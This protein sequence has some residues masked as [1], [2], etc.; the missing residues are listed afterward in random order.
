MRT[1]FPLVTRG[2]SPLAV[3]LL[4]TIFVA[5]AV[6]R[7]A[8]EPS[9]PLPAAGASAP[10]LTLRSAAVEDATPPRAAD[11]AL[12]EALLG[13]RAV[14]P[15]PSDADTLAPS[16]LCSWAPLEAG[17]I[18]G[19]LGP[20]DCRW[21]SITGPDAQGV[22]SA[23]PVDVYELRLDARSTLSVSFTEG[24]EIAALGLY[25]ANFGLLVPPVPGQG[26]QTTLPAGRFLLVVLGLGPRVATDYAMD[27]ALAPASAPGACEPEP[28]TAGNDATGRLEPTGCQLF[29][30][31]PGLE[32]DQPSAVYELRLDEPGEVSLSLAS[33]GAFVPMLS[34][35]SE[36]GAR[37]IATAR[38]D[39]EGAT[40]GTAALDLHLAPGAYWLLVASAQPGQGG[41][42]SLG[43]QLQPAGAVCEPTDLPLGET[44]NAGLFQDSCR[45]SYLSTAIDDPAPADVYRLV[46]PQTGLL[47]IEFEGSG[48]TAAA[49]VFGDRFET[50]LQDPDLLL[51]SP[52][53]LDVARPGTYLVAIQGAAGE[54]GD[55]SVTARLVPDAGTCALQTLPSLPQTI[56]GAL[57]VDD[58]SL[59]D[60]A[61]FNDDTKVDLYY[62]TLPER[63]RLSA[64]LVAPDF[65]SY[66]WVFS[67]RADF[68]IGAGAEAGE[69]A[70]IDDELPPGD[71]FLAAN[72]YQLELGSY[73]LDVDTTPVSAPGGCGPADLPLGVATE[74]T[75]GP[76]DCRLFDYDLGS[77]WPSYADAY[78]ILMPSRGRL[79]I[80]VTT[81]EEDFA[82]RAYLLEAGSNVLV[83]A[84]GDEIFQVA[85][86]S[87]ELMPG[88][89]DL[90]LDDQALVD[91]SPGA[92]TVETS[93]TPLPEPTCREVDIAEAYGPIPETGLV[94]EDAL[95]PEDCLMMDRPLGG[96]DQAPMHAYLLQVPQRGQ[97]RLRLQS[98]A[99][100]PFLALR[101]WHYE[102]VDFNDDVD[103]VFDP[104]AELDLFVSPGTYRIQALSA[105]LQVGAYI[106]TIE[107][108]P[109][110][111]EVTDPTPGPSPT[112]QPGPT[113]TPDPVEPTPTPGPGP[114]PY[115]IHLPIAL[116]G[117][118]DGS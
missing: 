111:F 92:Y 19:A 82:P 18:R 98:A 17:T 61:L 24:E 100:D 21:G 51:G 34:L 109:E 16:P 66:L 89:Y 2:A 110:R 94:I 70:T 77:R 26:V 38:G 88:A 75:L 49:R 54:V 60:W 39:D 117:G 30:F 9:K 4:A 112:V 31:L 81:Q 78:R 108:E 13:R 22:Y 33:D 23:A 40:A 42:Y 74:G 20:E 83:G 1:R 52:L 27:V 65:A 45:A 57:S 71:Y 105:D 29:D 11:E 116:D 97:L 114:G 43:S 107:F 86:L 63:A 64:S 85:E 37:A 32:L 68:W 28:F 46:V 87:F 59:R 76:G 103:P 99:L 58:C 56:D 53:D 62:V 36:G 8:A 90:Y 91:A 3:V 14:P 35:L 67:S 12:R 7:A 84:H 80:T 10:A 25:N 115:R 6:P 102:L 101:G 48:F 93:F 47:R 79:E 104:T 72:S 69:A 118:L 50:V 95:G 73:R 41:G 96:F 113:E 55:Y 106:L 44:R 15:S 5:G